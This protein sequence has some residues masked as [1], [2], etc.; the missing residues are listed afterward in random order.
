MLPIL[1]VNPEDLPAYAIVCGDPRE[2]R[3]HDLLARH[4]AIRQGGV[5][6]ADGG[7]FDRE[8]R[9]LRAGTGD[10]Q[11]EDDS[12]EGRAGQGE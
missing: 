2:M 11:P 1:Q 3:A 5:D 8:W 9:H 6:R 10:E 12:R 7:L 4:P